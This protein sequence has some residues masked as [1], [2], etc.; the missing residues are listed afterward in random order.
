MIEWTGIGDA[1]YFVVDSKTIDDTTQIA[2]ELE[3]ALS[4]LVISQ[5]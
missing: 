3:V 2:A 5:G 1:E 4:P